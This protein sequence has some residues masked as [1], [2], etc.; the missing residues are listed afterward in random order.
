MTTL[1]NLARFALVAAAFT[2]NQSA[3]AASWVATG[4][5][6]TA[7]YMHSATLLPSGKV[8]V[9]GG[10]TYAGITNSV[11]LYNP[12]LGTWTPA[13]PMN[14]ARTLHT[15]TLLSNGMVLVTGGISSVS[16]IKTAELYNPSLNTWT[17]IAPMATNRSYHSATLLPDGK[18]LVAGGF[19]SN[20]T[21]GSYVSLNSAEIYDPTAGTW[22]TTSTLT[23]AR[24]YHKAVLL[25]SGQVLLA[26]GS[27]STFNPFSSAEL[28]TP[29][30][31]KWTSTG[32]MQSPRAGFAALLLSNGKVLAAGGQDVNNNALNC[33]RLFK[34]GFLACS[35]PD[36]LLEAESA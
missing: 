9:A 25:P 10:N 18:V 30:T 21:V 26:G 11:E 22:T 23:V 1:K 32:T 15:A 31:G 35:K 24:G 3:Q 17:L 20:P 33:R 27:G 13:A 12:S 16:S 14:A 7:R 36:G 34:T 5:L 29:A 2:I 6:G 4:S 8:L 19:S 28:F